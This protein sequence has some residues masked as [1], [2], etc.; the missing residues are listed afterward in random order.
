MG[1]G[2]DFLTKLA[3]VYQETHEQSGTGGTAAKGAVRTCRLRILSIAKRTALLLATSLLDNAEVQM[4]KHVHPMAERRCHRRRLQRSA[5][6]HCSCS[7]EAKQAK[8]T[9]LRATSMLRSKNTS[10]AKQSKAGSRSAN[11]PDLAQPHWHPV[12]AFENGRKSSNPHQ[13]GSLV[14]LP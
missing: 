12:P 2:R 8:L 4:V 7:T 6:M 1:G 10:S 9:P 14:S 11:P 13:T 5:P 3:I